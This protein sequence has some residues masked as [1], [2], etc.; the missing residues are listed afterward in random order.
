MRAVTTNGRDV[1]YLVN[2]CLYNVKIGLI[3]KLRSHENVIFTYKTCVSSIFSKF[4]I[5]E[6]L[7]SI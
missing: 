4:E 1:K 5:I 7:T 2:E 3:D 6:A